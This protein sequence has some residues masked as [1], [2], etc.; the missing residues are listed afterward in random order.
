M[1]SARPILDESPRATSVIVFNHEPLAV[2]V[3]DPLE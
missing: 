3:N 2:S 1:H